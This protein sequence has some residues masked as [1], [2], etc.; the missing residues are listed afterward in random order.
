MKVKGNCVAFGAYSKWPLHELHLFKIFTYAFVTALQTI[1]CPLNRAWKF[2]NLQLWSSATML[3][4]NYTCWTQRTQALHNI[5]WLS[6]FKSSS[7]LGLIRNPV[8]REVLWKTNAFTSL[9]AKKN[10]LHPLVEEVLPPNFFGN[11]LETKEK[12]WKGPADPC[13]KNILDPCYVV[14]KFYF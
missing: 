14:I 9:L 10:I 2:E 11:V 7:V 13:V 1:C 3:K 4:L 12:C 8:L 5:W 6:F